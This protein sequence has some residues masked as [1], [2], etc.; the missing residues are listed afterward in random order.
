MCVGRDG[1]VEAARGQPLE[2]PHPVVGGVPDEPAGERYAGNIRL[3][4][5]RLRERAPQRIQELDLGVRPG[6]AAPADVQA[7]GV[8]PHFQA[9]AEPDE[10]I[11]SQS[12]AAFHAFQQESGTKRRKLQVRRHRCIQVCGN[13]ERRLHGVGA[14]LGHQWASKKNPS[15]SRGGDGFWISKRELK[16]KRPAPTP[17]GKCATTGGHCLSCLRSTCWVSIAAASGQRQEALR[18]FLILRAAS[19]KRGVSPTSSYTGSP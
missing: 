19:T 13:V 8:Q 17:S 12:L 6:R 10:R 2:V 4:L 15:P 3:R 9:V 11:A 18:V 16:L 1:R 7:G 14:I 5:R